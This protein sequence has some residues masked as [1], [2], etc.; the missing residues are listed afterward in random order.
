VPALNPPTLGKWRL[1]KA[2]FFAPII[3]TKARTYSCA[4]CHDPRHGF[5]E[6]ANNPAGAKFNTL[7]LINVVYNRRQFW[8]GRVETLEETIVRSIDDE[9]KMDADKRLE[10][11]LEQ[12]IWGGFV[13]DLIDKDDVDLR[14][15]FEAVF[16]IHRPTQDS[17]SQALATYMRTIL[18]GDSLYD[19]AVDGKEWESVIKDE[20]TASALRDSIDSQKPTLKELPGVLETGHKLYRTYCIQCHN[21]PLFTDHDYHNIGFASDPEPGTETGRAARVPVG[22]KEARLIGAFRTPS[23]RNLLTTNPYFHDGSKRTLRDVVA[24]FDRGIVNTRHLAAPL[25]KG[26][27]PQ[28]LDLTQRDE[29]ALVIFLRAL[30]GRPVDPM[31]T[32]P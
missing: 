22:L 26:I 4:T 8:D 5:A 7:S 6:D 16:A 13:R 12:H 27:M 24:Y 28:Y 21:G 3:T 1:G 14:R 17:V 2:L 15:Q 32:T 18:S 10:R 20:L 11:G 23:L 29:E 19:R 25:K 9:K 31:V 30:Q